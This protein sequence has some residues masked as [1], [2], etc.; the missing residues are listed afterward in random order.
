MRLA[1]F[2]LPGAG[3]GTQAEMLSNH[4]RIPHISTGD[5]FR[6]ILNSDSELAKEVKN[7]VTSGQLVSD[8]LVTKIAFNR[9]SKEDCNNGFILDG[10]PRTIT[11]VHSLSSSSYMISCLILI[12]VEE[13]EVIR[14]LSGRRLC[15][16][17][18]TIFHISS[19]SAKNNKYYCL[20]CN[21]ELIQRKDDLPE[22]ISVRLK[23]FNDNMRQ[24]FDFFKEKRMM[25]KI[26][27]NDTPENV[28]RSILYA[29]KNV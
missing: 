10:Y 27:G 21:N 17:C 12:E 3:K 4:F 5:L 19:L 25:F 28:F 20:K 9:L 1:L 29:L 16:N 14:R 13:E 23:I 22:V 2:G 18:T 24:V 7:V 11:Q 15:E 26:N 8:D 6:E